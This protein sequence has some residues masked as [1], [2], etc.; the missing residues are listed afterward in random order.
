[1]YILEMTKKTITL[2]TYTIYFDVLS[3]KIM[4]WSTPL[5][6]F[7]QTTG[8]NVI[9]GFQYQQNEQPSLILTELTEH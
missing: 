3:T 6:A 1:M 2:Y 5:N 7:L 8:G 4:I 9:I